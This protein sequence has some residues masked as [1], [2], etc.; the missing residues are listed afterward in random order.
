MKVQHLAD[1]EQ[2]TPNAHDDVRGEGYQKQLAD[3]DVIPGQEEGQENEDGD[4]RMD[5]DPEALK[6]YAGAGLD[7]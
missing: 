6:R 3:S 5:R 4:G 1:E 7:D 2:T